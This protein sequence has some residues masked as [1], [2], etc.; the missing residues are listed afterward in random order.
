MDNLIYWIK[1]NLTIHFE[2]YGNMPFA[3]VGWIWVIIVFFFGYHYFGLVLCII[4]SIIMVYNL[5]NR[6]W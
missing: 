4:L 1:R 5:L 3:R 6:K 2:F